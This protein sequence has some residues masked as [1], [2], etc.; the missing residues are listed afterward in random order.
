MA[1]YTRL[2]RRIALA[3]MIPMSLGTAVGAILTLC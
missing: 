2:K 1:E 3:F